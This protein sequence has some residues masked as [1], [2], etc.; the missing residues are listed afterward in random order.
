MPDAAFQPLPILKTERL[1]LRPL[2]LDDAQDQFEYAQDD[3]IAAFGL[4]QPLK[5]LQENIDDVQ[6]ALNAY[7]N[8]GAYIWA[9]EYRAD[10]KMIGRIQLG[11]YH[12]GVFADIGYA[13]NRLYWGKGYAS[14]AAHAVLKFGFETLKLHRIGATV[15][16]DNIGSIR[17]L[18]KMGFQREGVRRQIYALRGSF[19]D[20]LCYSILAPEWREQHSRNI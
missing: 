15:L 10:H 11:A 7:T 1:I 6:E 8:S 19:E 2:R 3:E 16:P 14:E 17:V 13:Y 9:V 18:E 4:W 20:L 5:T 12:A